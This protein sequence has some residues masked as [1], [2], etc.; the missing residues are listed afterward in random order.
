MPH[1]TASSGIPSSCDSGGD[2]GQSPLAHARCALPSS[3][4]AASFTASTVPGLTAPSNCPRK[5]VESVE[6]APPPT[7]PS[8][9]PSGRGVNESWKVSALAPR[10]SSRS[11][12]RGDSAHGDAKSAS[13]SLSSCLAEKA[14]ASAAAAE[15]ALAVKFARQRSVA[16]RRETRSV[17]PS[18]NGLAAAK[19]PRSPATVAPPPALSPPPPPSPHSATV[20]PNSS[21]VSRPL[22]LT[23][24]TPMPTGVGFA[25]GAT[26]V[27]AA[28]SPG[29][30]SPSSPAARTTRLASVAHLRRCFARAS[31]KA[32]SASPA[33]LS[34][35]AAASP[36]HPPPAREGAAAEAA[37]PPGG[38]SGSG[39]SAHSVPLSSPSK[40]PI[41]CRS[42]RL[43]SC[44]TERE[45]APRS[46]ERTANE[47][48]SRTVPEIAASSA[49]SPS[50]TGA[51]ARS[52]TRL[53]GEAP[54]VMRRSCKPSA[55]MAHSGLS[56]A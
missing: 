4:L 31:G 5:A 26:T 40:R 48:T 12:W 11:P 41:S 3:P 36:A 51:P 47:K 33:S 15:R 29:K 55:S 22:K 42:S 50:P 23:S 18:S 21:A 44:S 1:S 10:A 20:S 6:V 8:A 32:P 43:E 35:S 56:A 9:P 16:P 7:P 14:T 49:P 25:S 45:T 34:A 52:S 28:T 46:A 19:L 39:A 27:T 54:R 24:P 30:S 2:G 38:G 53:L 13:E 17:I 37:A